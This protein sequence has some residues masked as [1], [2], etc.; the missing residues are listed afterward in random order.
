MKKLA[1][2]LYNLAGILTLPFA[3]V[4]MILVAPFIY[5]QENRTRVLNWVIKKND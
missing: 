5:I 2:L 1:Y 3:L 4:G